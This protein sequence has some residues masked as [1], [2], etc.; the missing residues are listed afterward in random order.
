MAGQRGLSRQRALRQ[1]LTEDVVG[2]VAREFQ[3]VYER[4]LE[5]AA[6]AET[7]AAGAQILAHTLQRIALAGD[8]ISAT[9]LRA[10]AKQTLA[11]LA[12]PLDL[13]TEEGF[14]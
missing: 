11:E 7:R 10:L 14:L 1:V 3:P 13:E 8:E 2:A 12:I 9:M 5:R 6:D 4:A